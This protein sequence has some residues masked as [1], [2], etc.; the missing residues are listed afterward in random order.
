[1]LKKKKIIQKG[2]LV[3]IEKIVILDWNIDFLNTTF[4]MNFE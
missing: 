4:S 2:V 1:M 3:I